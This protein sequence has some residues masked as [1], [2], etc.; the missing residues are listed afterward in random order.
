MEFDTN[1]SVVTTV[2]LKVC[3]SVI[4]KRGVSAA[5]VGNFHDVRVGRQHA[6]RSWTAGG[7]W[8]WNRLINC[9][10]LTELGSIYRMV[11]VVLD[12]FCVNISSLTDH[13]AKHPRCFSLLVWLVSVTDVVFCV[14]V[15]VVCTLLTTELWADK[16][17]Q[18]FVWVWKSRMLAVFSFQFSFPFAP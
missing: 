17:G 15:T 4:N 9:C 12:F 6:A 3:V 11:F 1:R 18:D 2:A 13:S 10:R 5:S 8:A 7:V 16:P 14:C